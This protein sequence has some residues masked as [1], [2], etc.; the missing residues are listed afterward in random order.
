VLIGCPFQKPFKR[1]ELAFGPARD[2][3]AVNLLQA[4]DVGSDALKCRT[5]HG[6]PGL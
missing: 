3:L 2:V 6:S 1:D 4:E 5:Q